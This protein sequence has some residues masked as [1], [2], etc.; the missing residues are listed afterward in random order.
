MDDFEPTWELPDAKS[1]LAEVIERALTEGPQRITLHDKQ[2]VYVV[3]EEAYDRLVGHVGAGQS[4]L[5]FFMASPLWGS[6]IPIERIR[7]YGR[8]IDFETD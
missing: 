6:G 2:S 3:A 1:R 4:L 5:D 8:D 7:G